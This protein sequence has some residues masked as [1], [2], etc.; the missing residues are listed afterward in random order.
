MKKPNFFFIGAPKCGTTSIAKVLSQHPNIFISNP[1]EPHF[2]E[3]EIP[4]GIKS[5]EA[6]ESLFSKVRNHHRIVG[7]AS[8]GYLYSKTA[9]RK[10]LGY[11]PNAKFLVS[12]RNPYEMAI[13]LYSHALRGKYE[14]EHDFSMAWKLQEA[15]RSGSNIPKTCC[16]NL[17]LL[18]GD[19]CALGDQLERLYNMVNHDSVCLVFFDDLRANP[20]KLYDKIYKFLELAGDQR[21][22]FPSLNKK[23][24]LRWQYLP[25]ITHSLGKTKKLFGIYRSLGIANWLMGITSTNE[26][27]RQVISDDVWKDMDEK[28]VSQIQKIEGITGRDLSYWYYYR[29]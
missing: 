14:N 17:L 10:I 1:K 6:Y 23:I 5:L 9:V 8:T 25:R 11:S 29:N 20:A 21:T 26:V 4:R 15:R 2:F 12:V 16:C 28:F 18:Y 3:E 27:K 7:E 19:R 24:T 22:E 13:S